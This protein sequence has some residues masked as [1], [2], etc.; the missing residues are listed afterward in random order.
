MNCRILIGPAECLNQRILVP[1][2]EAIPGLFIRAEPR[3]E[4]GHRRSLFS[5]RER[6][7]AVGQQLVTPFPP[8]LQA[9]R[10][11]VGLVALPALVI[12]LHLFEPFNR[13]GR[14]RTLFQDSNKERVLLQIRANRMKLRR[15]PPSL[16]P[17]VNPGMQGNRVSFRALLVR[18]SRL[19]PGSIRFGQISCKAFLLCV[20]ETLSALVGR[21]DFVHECKLGPKCVFSPRTICVE[22]RPELANRLSSADSATSESR[23]DNAGTDQ[24]SLRPAR[25]RRQLPIAQYC[26]RRGEVTELAMNVVRI[27]RLR[28][29]PPDKICHPVPQGDSRIR[30]DLDGFDNLSRRPIKSTNA[31]LRLAGPLHERNQLVGSDD[32]RE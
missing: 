28:M 13:L 25:S 11:A 1:S 4:V 8:F 20:A 9:L 10:F 21:T 6:V 2:I 23:G 3:V 17:A 19:D 22:V 30:P 24:V 31:L 16:I 7:I 15:H 32:L 18:K 29:P 12:A 14:R 5:R 26:E 27:L